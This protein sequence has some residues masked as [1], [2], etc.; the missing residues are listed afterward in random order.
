MQKVRKKPRNTLI[1]KYFNIYRRVLRHWFENTEGPV[2][3]CTRFSC[4]LD[5][6]ISNFIL[7]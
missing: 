3:L 7:L 2:P 5:R 1:Y 6:K 4:A